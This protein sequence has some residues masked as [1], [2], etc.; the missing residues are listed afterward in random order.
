MD[1]RQK[2]VMAAV[3]LLM[4]LF[5]VL[6]YLHHTFFFSPLTFQPD[7]IIYLDWSWYRR[8]LQVGI[9][10]RTEEGEL[11]GLISASSDVRRVIHLL[12]QGLELGIQPSTT[13]WMSSARKRVRLD[14]RCPRRGTN[15]LLVQGAWD[16]P[17]WEAQSQD[18]FH[19]L[20]AC[21]QLRDL[22]R[23]A[24]GYGRD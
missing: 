9:D 2:M 6:G 22:I 18:G 10:I 4:S 3:L 20:R 13:S 23:E 5:V 15:L 16:N 12:Q 14:L 21:P 24:T 17:L 8:P 11:Q 7:A 1:S 19:L